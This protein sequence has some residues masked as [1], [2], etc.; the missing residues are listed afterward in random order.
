MKKFV[1]FIF[2]LLMV[3]SRANALTVEL[4]PANPQIPENCRSVWTFMPTVPST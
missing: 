3:V 4:A 1:M 2:V